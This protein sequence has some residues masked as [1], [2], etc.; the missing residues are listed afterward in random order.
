M[1]IECVLLIGGMVGGGGRM[2]GPCE[3]I[4]GERADGPGVAGGG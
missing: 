3:Y 1:R 2:S 4:R